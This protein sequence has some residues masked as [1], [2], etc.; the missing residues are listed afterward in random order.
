MHH[1]INI[2]YF[3]QGLFVIGGMASIINGFIDVA[4]IAMFLFYA[5]NFLSSEMRR[6][7]QKKVR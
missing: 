5:L 1:A 7:A 4:I 2:L 3:L 6:K